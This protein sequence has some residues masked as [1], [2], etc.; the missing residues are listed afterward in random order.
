ME[1]NAPGTNAKQSAQ[2]MSVTLPNTN[3]PQTHYL[4]HRRPNGRNSLSWDLARHAY[5]RVSVG[6]ILVLSDSPV[7]LLASFKKQW[8]H[9]CRRV[10]RE[11]ASTFN[12]DYIMQFTRQISLMQGLNATAESPL[13]VPDADLYILTPAQVVEHITLLP[14]FRT[15]YVVCDVSPDSSRPYR[16]TFPNAPWSLLNGNFANTLLQLIQDATQ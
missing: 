14:H 16:P 2:D 13:H 9:L 8:L 1:C 15:L 4:E 7:P 10:Q 5:T 11:R 3:L 6:R 12:T